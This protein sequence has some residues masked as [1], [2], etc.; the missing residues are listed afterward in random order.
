MYFLTISIWIIGLYASIRVIIGLIL[1]ILHQAKSTHRST[2]RIDYNPLLTV[3]IPAYNEEKTI[4]NCILSVMKQT[5][6]NIQLVVVNDGSKDRTGKILREL[7]STGDKRFLSKTFKVVFQKNSGKSNAINN[8]IKNYAKGELVMIL[9][10]D[11]MLEKDTIQNM[12]AHFS[13]PNVIAMSSNVRIRHSRRMIEFVQQIEYLLGYRLKGTEQLLR[14]E[15]IIGGV[16]STFRKSAIEMV[17]YY[18]TDTATEDID[19]TLKLLSYF[20]N[21]K[22][23]FGYAIDSIAYTPPVHTFSQLVKQRYRW[24]LGR[25]Q[26]LFKY[27]KLLLNIHIK[28]YS[29]TLSWWK[30]PKVFFEELFIFLDPF[31]ACWMII[32]IISHSNFSPLYWLILVYFI[33]SFFTL[34]FEKMNNNEKFKLMMFSPISYFMLYTINIVDF[35]CLIGCLINVK[36]V[37][38]RKKSESKWEHVS[39]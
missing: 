24:K 5:Y 10:A 9:D 32:V 17:G 15:Y 20:G 13:N 33:F 6:S 7:S 37:F 25:F 35:I 4:R 29:F 28:K 8:A 19:I 36:K 39:R 23:L 27:Y 34:V 3:V 14:L 16:G 38:K 30:L 12:V 21:K 11:S 2:T 22:W 31:I 26:V 1:S 18:D